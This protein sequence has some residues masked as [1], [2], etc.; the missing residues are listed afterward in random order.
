MT[1]TSAYEQE[2][3]ANIARNRALLEQLDLKD[4]GSSLGAYVK[5]KP[6]PKPKAKPIQPSKRVKREATTEAPRR[7]SSRLKK[8]V[9]DP[10]ET[11]VQKRKR[12]AE[13]EERRIKEEE[14]RIQAEEQARLAKRP[15]TQDLDI[16]VLTAAEELDDQEIGALRGSLQAV[17]NVSIPRCI[18]DVGAWVYDDDKKDEGEVQALRERLGKM[19]V[20]S[21]AK[22]TQD[23][24][25]SAAYHPE[26]TKDLVFFG[27]KHG[28]LGIWD[29]RAPA[30]EVA[31]EDG[32]V[33][34]NDEKE[35]GKYWRLQQH[36]P[37]TSKSSIS[38]IRIDPIDSH[39][40]YTTSYDCTIRQLSFVSGISQ[41]IFSSPDVLITSLDL[42]PS[43]HE[44]WISDASG[45]VTHLDLREGSSQARWYGLSDQKIGS[46]SL[47]P[48]TPHLVLTASNNRLLKIWDTRKLKA[49]TPPKHG[50]VVSPS[51]SPL[52][53][54]FDEVQKFAESKKGSG[55]LRGECP[56]GKSVSSAYWDPRGRSIVSTSYDDTLRLWELDAGKYD[57]YPVF[58]S[59][60]PFSRIK[61][62]CQTG[63]WLT[64]LRA[65]WNP[66]PDVYPHFTVGNLEHSLD[67]F[68]CKGDL[69]TRLSDRQ[70]ITAT[71]AVTCS[72]PS[73]VERCATGNGS[74]RCVLWAPSDS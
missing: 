21:R 46:V 63:K 14:E 38:S 51:S 56:H 60:T 20:V 44:M 58:P 45:G 16:P 3:E 11:P 59:F 1:E 12:E 64:I 68:S 72:H 13:T 9:V 7:Q 53:Y 23:R 4:A 71:Q 31:D 62:N 48:T 8:D 43:G 10:N 54:D 26:P 66:N 41:Q 49:L 34:P 37:A 22:V 70:R 2:R 67:I 17:T 55:L 35:G 32:D 33:V 65:V 73:I 50:S 18:E 29:A 40:L 5:P 30:D 6:A 28:Q 36:W 15:R 57:S 24:V 52:E 61:H 39:S 19:K 25:Y 74:G 69:I 47:N 42:L 27:D